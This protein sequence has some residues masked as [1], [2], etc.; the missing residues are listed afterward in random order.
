MANQKALQAAYAAGV[1]AGLKSQGIK[2]VTNVSD[3]VDQAGQL[4]DDWTDLMTQVQKLI[5]TFKK[6]RIDP[7]SAY[8]DQI[9]NNADP[10]WRGIARNV[11]TDVPEP[12]N[13]SS[14]LINFWNNY[15]QPYI[16]F[17]QS[18]QYA[19]QHD[20]DPLAPKSTDQ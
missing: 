6:D 3:Y 20:E 5:S 9:K 11:P 8:V 7:L 1:R 12:D 19:A 14:T 16:S 10:T 13:D 15:V 18:M 2:A 4:K 17:N